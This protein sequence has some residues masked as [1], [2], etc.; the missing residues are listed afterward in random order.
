MK[1][2]FHILWLLL[3]ALPCLA[4]QGIPVLPLEVERLPDMLEPR[5]SHA[6]LWVNGEL[7]AIGGHTT[8]FVPSQTAEYF[9]DGRWHRTEDPLYPH[10]GGFALP[11]SDG[12]I[13]V[14]AGFAQP[15]GIGQTWGMEWYDP[16]DHSFSPAGILS[17]KRAFAS[18]LE[19]PD[20]KIMVT[21]NHYDGDSIEVLDQDA[22]PLYTQT[23]TEPRRNPLLLQ[24]SDGDVVI[25]GEHA[26]GTGWN[27]FCDLLNGAA[28]PSTLEAEWTLNCNTFPFEPERF[29]IAPATY[30][31]PT[32]RK[33]EIQP[34]AFVVFRDGRF[35]LLETDYAIPQLS[36]RGDTLSWMN[37]A[38]VTDRTARC[39][40]IPG[41]DEKGYLYLLRI[42][43][44]PALD[45]GKARLSLLC[46]PQP[47]PIRYTETWTRLL[48]LGRIAMTGGIFHSN[49]EPTAAA[50]IL[51]PTG[52]RPA[53]D[54]GHFPW[55]PVVVIGVLL[56]ALVALLLTRR[57]SPSPAETPSP[58]QLEESRMDQ[59][60][61]KLEQE[62]MYLRKGLTI[63]DFAAELHTNK[64]YISYLLNRRCGK[65]FSDFLNGYRVEHAKRLMREQ[66]QLNLAEVAD[67]SGFADESSF[68]RNFKKATGL[69]PAAWRKTEKNQ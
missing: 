23:V 65:S 1:K 9:R 35:S 68:Y 18:A 40:Y 57:V 63:T 17:R 45:G 20:G 69:T 12:R 22:R 62:K 13:L 66:P 49:F 56:A 33:G 34:S 59:I 11:L 44:N 14:G 51:H 32:C 3:T 26:D 48:P 46:T 28:Q 47:L 39:S 19:L 54:T 67:A 5:Y 4:Q 64:T 6:L 16:S 27:A 41:S 30:L 52:T 61:H 42:D 29:A 36:E 38:F 43:Y 58:E 55:W 25:E 50:W 24:T 31:F 10:D 37:S 21:G 15:F 8:G 53:P 60:I 2:V 7:V